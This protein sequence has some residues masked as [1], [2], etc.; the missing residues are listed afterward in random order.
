MKVEGTNLELAEEEK[1]HKWIT[2]SKET[3]DCL[4][5]EI[6]YG[7]PVQRFTVSDGLTASSLKEQG[8]HPSPL[9]SRSKDAYDTST[10]Y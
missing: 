5:R 3:Q 2:S 4:H 9:K 1:Y 6:P 10:Y 8:G 7:M